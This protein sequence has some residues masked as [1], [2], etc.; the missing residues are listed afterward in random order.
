MPHVAASTMQYLTAAYRG[1]NQPMFLETL[2]KV[3]T[4]NTC[5]GHAT[6]LA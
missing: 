1:H 3:M 2:H 4:V 6:G 5:L